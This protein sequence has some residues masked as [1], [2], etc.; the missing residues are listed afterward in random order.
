MQRSPSPVDG[1]FCD[2]LLP[3]PIPI[4]KMPTGLTQFQ[5]TLRLIDMALSIVNT[6]LVVSDDDADDDYQ[7]V[8]RGYDDNDCNKDKQ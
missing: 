8:Q 5:K 4:S 7:V 3:L 2:F 6:D 1:E